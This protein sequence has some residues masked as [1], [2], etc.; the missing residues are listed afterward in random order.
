MIRAGVSSRLAFFRACQTCAELFIVLWS[1]SRLNR[2]CQLYVW[3]MLH[4]SRFE[5]T[6]SVN[7][8]TS[9]VSFN[10]S[11]ATWSSSTV[12][13]GIDDQFQTGRNLVWGLIFLDC[14]LSFEARK[15]AK[16]ALWR[17]QSSDQ[18]CTT[19]WNN[20]RP[21]NKWSAWMIASMCMYSMSISTSRVFRFLVASHLLLRYLLYIGFI[22]SRLLF[23]LSTANLFGLCD[24]WLSFFEIIIALCV[25]FAVLISSYIQDCSLIQHSYRLKSK[26]SSQYAHQVRFFRPASDSYD[27]RSWLSSK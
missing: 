24:L 20:H 3:D 11:A 6:S 4:C 18:V 25:S 16:H 8:H 5:F 23:C 17:V 2:R 22:V 27:I 15:C 7:Q 1:C 19:T 26:H 10:V 13:R 14:H 12:K 21:R 9:V